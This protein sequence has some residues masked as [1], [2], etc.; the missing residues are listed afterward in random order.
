MLLALLRDM[1]SMKCF[2]TGN[3]FCHRLQ[4]RKP[5]SHSCKLA[6][7]KQIE[8]PEPTAHLEKSEFVNSAF[9]NDTFL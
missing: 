1:L 9:L 2:N 3:L 8:A 5:K 6:P 7:S 4:Q